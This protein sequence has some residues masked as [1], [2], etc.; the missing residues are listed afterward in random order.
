MVELPGYFRKTAGFASFCCPKNR[1]QHMKIFC[2]GAWSTIIFEVNWVKLHEKTW[3][4][5]K[6][7]EIAQE[8]LPFSIVIRDELKSEL[9]II[10]IGN[11]GQ[12]LCAAQGGRI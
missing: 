9:Y 2:A 10:T 3:G 8:N 11:R 7:P 12:K 1:L 5:L 6:K 4:K